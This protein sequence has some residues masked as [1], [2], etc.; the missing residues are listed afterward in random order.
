MKGCH[1]DVLCLVKTKRFSVVGTADGGDDGRRCGSSNQVDLKNENFSS[2]SRRLGVFLDIDEHYTRTV[3]QKAFRHPQREQYF[4]IVLGP[5][6]G[7]DAV[8][9]PEQCKFQWAEYER[10][11]WDAVQAG[12]HKASSYMIRKGLS[13]KAQLAYYT[14]LYVCKH[15]NSILKDAIPKT[16]ILDTWSVWDDDTSTTIAGSGGLADVIVSIGG[17]SDKDNISHRKRLDSCLA[18]ARI[19]MEE[20][21]KDY[22]A[23]LSLNAPVWI[24][25][26]STVNKGAGI[27]IVHHY[28]Q[29]V[30]HC[31]TESDIREW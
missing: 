31:W 23:G 9:I 28:E 20:A 27:H 10:I 4:H 1:H 8:V 22:E 16:I 29:I 13:R 7:M 21:D 19:A 24:L 3:I 17:T 12:K 18:D 2:T 5:G 30:D 6:V 26:G 25:K 14:R 15:P 11:D